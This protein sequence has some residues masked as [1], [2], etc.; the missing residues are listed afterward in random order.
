MTRLLVDTSVLI[1]WFHT[2][3]EADVEAARDILKAHVRGEVTAHILDLAFYEVG[4][5]LVRALAWEAAAVSGQLDD[6]RTIL[7]APIALN[8]E[9]LRDAATLAEAHT[10]SFYDASW[11]AAARGF[12]VALVSADQRLQRAG[13]AESP[14]E[15]TARLRL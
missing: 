13:L 6:L 12:G 8:A 11:A 2:E 1:K 5:V 14:T 3:G 15:T 7:G 9:M 10:L 4:N